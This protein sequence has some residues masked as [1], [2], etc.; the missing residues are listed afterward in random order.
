MV[1]KSFVCLLVLAVI[2]SVSASAYALETLPGDFYELFDLDGHKFQYGGYFYLP[3]GEYL[4][5]FK[6][7]D[8]I[9]EFPFPITIDESQLTE[10]GDYTVYFNL[11]EIRVKLSSANFHDGV[12]SPV[13]VL[14]F[15]DAESNTHLSMDFVSIFLVPV[16][17]ETT[18]ERNFFSA[19]GSAILVAVSWLGISFNPSQLGL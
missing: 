3:H 7:D 5:Y 16:L 1:K 19:V 11:E 2:F 8:G 4:V 6:F 14:S 10:T 13:T 12:G 9:Q 15:R 18:S 17:E